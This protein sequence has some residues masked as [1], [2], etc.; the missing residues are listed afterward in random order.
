MSTRG[1]EECEVVE[2]E[3][4]DEDDDESREEEEETGSV[5]REF[6]ETK[7]VAVFFEEGATESADTEDDEAKGEADERDEPREETERDDRVF[8]DESC[9]CI[10]GDE[11]E[12]VEEEESPR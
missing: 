11:E 4:V 12:E 8:V 3:F 2:D 7:V 10:K 5:R 6:A 9:S 1:E